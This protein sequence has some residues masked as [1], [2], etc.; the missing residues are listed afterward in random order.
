MD[1]GVAR[2]VVTLVE[3]L[4]RPSASR[5]TWPARAARL[6]WDA[7]RGGP[8]SRC[9]RSSAHREPRAGRRALVARRW[10]GSPGGPTSS[11][12]TR[13]RPASSA[14]SRRRC[15]GRRRA[16]VFTPHGWSFWAADGA[17]GAAVPGARAARRALVRGD[18]RAVRRTSATAG[19]AA[20]IGRPEQYR[21]I[22]NGVDARAVR[23]A[24][25]RRC[26]GRVLMVGRLAPPKRPDVAIRA[27]R[28]A[29][30]AR[31]RRPSCT[32]SAT[33][34]CARR[35]SAL[36]AELGLGG[37]A[38]SLGSREDVP[39]LLARGRVRAA[40]ERLRG[41]PARRRRGD[42]R[43]ARRSRRPRSAGWASS[44]ARAVTGALGPQGRRGGARAGA[45]G[46]AAAD[47]E[48]AARWAPRAAG[49]RRQSCRSSAWSGGW[50]PLRGARALMPRTRE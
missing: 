42:G 7:P 11:T 23:A 39:E 28:R 29:C 27:R 9:T 43:A 33:A 26:A 14:G 2:H 13:R 38:R 34:R 48:R 46:G 10:S 21:V 25:P 41:L 32:S 44:C 15:A 22:P 47:P 17:R 45:R 19:L 5:S 40:R 30:A 37:S 18:R 36:A 3:A 16:C 8:A 35:P 4:F 31:C 24:R 12:S 1:G 49:S 6:T 50:S 20:G